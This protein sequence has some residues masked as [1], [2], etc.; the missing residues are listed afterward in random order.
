M[1]NT[2]NFPGGGGKKSAQILHSTQKSVWY[3]QIA[4]HILFQMGL[5]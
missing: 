4:Y 5:F 2:V 3:V 1:W